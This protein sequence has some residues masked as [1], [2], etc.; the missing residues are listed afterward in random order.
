MLDLSANMRVNPYEPP[1]RNSDPREHP[2]W[3]VRIRSFTTQRLSLTFIAA[4]LVGLYLGVVLRAGFV[5]ATRD[6]VTLRGLSFFTLFSLIAAI[7]SLF[8]R[9]VSSP[10]RVT[11]ARIV[12]GLSFGS[13]FMLL[14]P[15]A[16]RM[17]RT[18]PEYDIRNSGL[19]FFAILGSSVVIGV[20]AQALLT[21]RGSRQ[22]EL[23]VTQK[24][25]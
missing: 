5:T 8:Y 24:N 19:Y 23:A 14:E 10:R 21:S 15:Y 25:G 1:T 4:S 11:F 9:P 3:F 22:T 7:A 18:H 20:F 2:R 6:T 12:G 17:M 16:N 13:A